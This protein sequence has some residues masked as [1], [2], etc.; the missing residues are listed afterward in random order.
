VDNV[1]EGMLLAAEKGRGG[2]A[3]FLTDGPPVELRAFVTQMLATRGV[4]PGDKSVPKWLVLPLAR[5][6][7]WAWQTLGLKGEPPATRMAVH[8]FGEPV[9]VNDAK[10]RREL[11]YVG[12]VTREQ[13]MASL[14]TS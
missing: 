2:E 14:K 7:E 1:C 9:T 6:C 12:T 10:A 3:Y 4:D 8:L 13:G 5:V 11:G